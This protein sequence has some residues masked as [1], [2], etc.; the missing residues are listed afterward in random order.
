MG[1][2]V[3]SLGLYLFLDSVLLHRHSTRIRRRE[4]VKL[5]F[6]DS[7]RLHRSYIL[8]CWRHHR[9][10]RCRLYMT[11]DSLRLKFKHC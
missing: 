2:V 7:S 9:K 8:Q 11:R 5:L 1:I 10:T 3:Y 6:Q 4:A